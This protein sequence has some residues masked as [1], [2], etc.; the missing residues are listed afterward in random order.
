MKSKR[1]VKLG[2]FVFLFVLPLFASAQEKTL[3]FMCQEIR[4]QNMVPQ[5]M[6]NHATYVEFYD[7]GKR[8]KLLDGTT[9]VYEG[10]NMYGVTSYR[11]AGT[12]GPQMPNTQYQVL[13]FNS[14]FSMMQI[15]YVFGMMGMYTQMMSVWHFIGEGT[16]PAIKWM[17]GE[18]N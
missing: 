3:S 10:K 2:M 16:E 1:F 17:N 8:I 14:N 6:N 12:T 4:A 13:T 9:W 7:G 5:A 15:G 18:F 11:Y